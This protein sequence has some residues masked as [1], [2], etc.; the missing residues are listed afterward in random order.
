M[1][2]NVVLVLLQPVKYQL[3]IKWGDVFFI[4]A[5]SVLHPL[6]KRK[7]HLKA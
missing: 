1:Q 7:R 3:Q 2:S 5:P 6:L 4:L